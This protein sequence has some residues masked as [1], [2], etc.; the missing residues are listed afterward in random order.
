MVE[1]EA[2]MGKSYIGAWLRE[3]LEENGQMR[4]LVIR[5]EPQAQQGGGLRAALLR[6]LGAPTADYNEAA[7]VFLE[8]FDDETTREL[9]MRVLWPEPDDPRSADQ[10]V[11]EAAELIKIVIGDTPFM[12]W[13]D[14]AQWSPEG[15]VLKLIR[16]LAR[17]DGLSHLLVLV[18]LRPSERSAVQTTC[19]D[20]LR[21][22]GAE[23]IMLGPVSPLEL[24]PALESLAPLP[25]GLAEAASMV[26]AGN[27]LIAVEAVRS[28][29]ESEGL[30][31]APTD[32]NQVLKQRIETTTSGQ[33]GGELLSALARATLLGR[34]FTLGPLCKLCGVP[35]DPQAAALTGD[36]ET[37]L[38]LLEEA[39]N[40]GLAV[41][42]GE[43]RWR[44]GHDLIRSQLR[45]TC[46]ELQNWP[47]QLESRSLR[48]ERSRVDQPV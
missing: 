37:V 39:V 48:L 35:G 44:F 45:K 32:P 5:S 29:L 43:R 40:S 22:P 33:R 26:A 7:E 10:S 18:T 34:S 4:T 3:Q 19:K 14:D 15:R 41:E 23:S 28:F 12:L 38:G 36:Q 2:G 24:A 31:H 46:R 1:G 9:A 21:L 20:L 16:R 6:L 17:P 8:T 42:Q 25:E 11:R 27:P 47:Q 13:S 30:G